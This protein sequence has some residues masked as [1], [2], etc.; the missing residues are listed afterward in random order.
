MLEKKFFLPTG[1]WQISWL[2]RIY[3]VPRYFCLL[4]HFLK[5]LVYFGIECYIEFKVSD[6]SNFHI[7]LRVSQS[8]KFS[9]LCSLYSLI[10]CWLHNYITVYRNICGY[11]ITKQMD[12]LSLAWR[13]PE[14]SLPKDNLNFLSL[15]TSTNKNTSS[16]YSNSSDALSYL[17]GVEGTQYLKSMKEW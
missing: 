1:N 3:T 13:K 11:F 8:T 6:T 4:E 5:V 2:I 9:A 15:Y 10:F 17:S 16:Y 7:I 14:V 12:L